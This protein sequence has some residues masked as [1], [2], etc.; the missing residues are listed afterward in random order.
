MSVFYETYEFFKN[1]STKTPKTYGTHQDKVVIL[2]FGVKNG[3]LRNVLKRNYSAVVVPY[4]YDFDQ[5]MAYDP[6]V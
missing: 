4:N 1:V 6:K 2:D 5:I 3:I